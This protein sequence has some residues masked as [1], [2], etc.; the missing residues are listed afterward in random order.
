M[1]T[2]FIYSALAG[3]VVFA[4]SP[5]STNYVLP[6]YD[7][8]SGGTDSSSST[9]YM[10]NGVSGT[11]TG[12]QHTSTSYALGSGYNPTL[13]ANVP[14]A[15]TLSNPS[16]YYDKLQLTINDGG[17]PTDTVFLIAVSPDNFVTTYY[18]QP[19]NSISLSYTLATY[20]TYA[21]YGSG[22]GFL[23]LGLNPNTTYTAKVKAMR[24]NFTESAYSP[25]S[26]GVATVGQVLSFGLT[27][28]LTVTPPF[29]ANF[30]SLSAGTVFAADADVNI[31]FTTNANAGGSVYIKSANG[32]LSS[33]AASYSITSA[34]TD[35]AV[36][37]KGYGVQVTSATQS[38]GG[39]I[40]SQ[41]PFN[42][43]ADNVGALTSVLQELV[44]SSNP[45]TAAA[46]TFRIKAKTDP[47]VP[48]M[49][50]YTDQLTVVAAMNY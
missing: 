3:L 10:L 50:D 18:V 48:S 7:F 14:A 9:S 42:G 16:S 35:L 22:S 8:G 11:Q 31:N 17:N 2:E 45:V 49:S 13:N 15:P 43:A 37:S 12:T 41:A 4:A 24:G 27:T 32:A 40:S 6:A 47:L 39:P 29:I 36:A 21:S 1:F 23:L 44:R 5:T 25:V 20:R 38:S 19:D 34:T 28:T 26:S 46:S 30:S 33:V